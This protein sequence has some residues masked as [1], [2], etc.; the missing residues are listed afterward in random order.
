MSKGIV[1]ARERP[2]ELIDIETGDT[3]APHNGSVSWNAYRNRWIMIRSRVEGPDS[4]LGEV[5]YF[6]ADTPLGPWAYGQRIITHTRSALVDSTR[7]EARETYTFYNPVQHPELDRDGGR[8]VFIEGTLSTTFAV[9]PTPPMPGYEYNQMMYRLDLGNP[10]VFLPVAI[11][12]AA[13]AGGSLYRTRAAAANRL[14]RS[15]EPTLRKWNLAFFAPDRP[16]PSTIPVH[17]AASATGSG[18]RLVGGSGESDPPPDLLL[19]ASRGSRSAAHCAPVRGARRGR[20]L[21]LHARP[22]GWA[23]QRVVSGVAG[24]GRLHAR[25]AHAAN[26]GEASGGTRFR[27]TPLKTC[28]YD[29]RRNCP[30]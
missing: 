29:T 13:D 12:R 7:P 24:A 6:E 17:E 14:A 26:R 4:F 2:F 8:E 19:R 20:P 10:R 15:G 5:Y 21:E 30:L 23:R 28:E 22:S 18:L 9:P 11:Y 27:A 1:T 3:V 25:A 16:R